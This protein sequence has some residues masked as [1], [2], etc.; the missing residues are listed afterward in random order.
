MICYLWVLISYTSTPDHQPMKPLIKPS[1][2]TFMLLLVP[3]LSQ[4]SKSTSCDSLNSSMSL[5]F[6]ESFC[7]HLHRCSG[8]GYCYFEACHCETLDGISYFG[9]QCAYRMSNS[10]SHV[11]LRLLLQINVVVVGRTCEECPEEHGR[12]IEG[13]CRCRPGWFGPSCD[14]GKSPLLFYC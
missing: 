1:G 9:P 7:L 5:V 14:H 8:H 12:C 6:L 2:L 3:L 4:S 10:P 13:I 11:A